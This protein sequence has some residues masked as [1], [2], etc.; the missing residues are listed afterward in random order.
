[1]LGQGF[2][3][4]ESW[5]AWLTCLKA[6]HALPMDSGELGIFKAC[7]KR[8]Q[9][10]LRPV[11]EAYLIIGRGGGKSRIA[12]AE[13]VYHGSFKTYKLAPGERAVATSI[14]PE[15]KQSRIVFNYTKAIFN[16]SP[17]LGSL[18]ERVTAEEIDLK[19]NVSCEIHTSSFRTLRGYSI[20][21]AVLDEVAFFR[22]EQSQNPDVEILNALR[23]ALGKIPGSLLL[24]ISSPYGRRGVLWNAYRK[25]FGVESDRVLVW[26]ADTLTM[27][28]TFDSVIIQEAFEQ[29]EAV[30]ASEYGRDGTIQFRQDLESFVDRTVV[31]ACVIPSRFELPYLKDFQYSAFCDPSG[32]SQDS[33]TLTIAH[34]EEKRVVLDAIRER[35]PPFS[36]ENVIL[37]FVETLK[38]Y[39]I[40]AVRGDK[41]GG[42]WPRERFRV[43]G[44]DYQIAEKT[45]SEYYQAFLPIINSKNVDLLDLPKLINQ[46]VS[47]ERRTGR[48]GKDSIDHSV[49]SHDDVV[50][51]VAGVAVELI[52][53]SGVPGILDYY[54]N[55]K[56]K[57][58]EEE[59]RILG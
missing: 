12:A 38:S 27:N 5:R 33:M 42:E 37:E 36:P 47:L 10:P 16:S 51:S 49:G 18:V 40:K 1:M 3:D 17:M 7:T 59:R 56:E 13:E 28:P 53:S 52:G 39:Q 32:G 57:R 41:Y 30:A 21:L 25:Y 24:C 2:G 9:P 20:C 4:L 50:N 45:K 54:R 23:P 48:S 29:D 11:S 22:D 14:S 34:R 35:R 55:L 15:R 19:N 58:D 31:E 46:L 8:E 43:N 6:I 44:V 26:V